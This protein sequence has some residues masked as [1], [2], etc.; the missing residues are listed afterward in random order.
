MHEAGLQL[1]RNGIVAFLDRARL[2]LASMQL[3]FEKYQDSIVNR[4]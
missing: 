3:S 2:T 1:L 4:E